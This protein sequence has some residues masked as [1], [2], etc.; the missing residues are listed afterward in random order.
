MTSRILTLPKNQQE[1][2]ED[3]RPGLILRK[4]DI[5]NDILRYGYDNSLMHPPFGVRSPNL[6]V[7]NQ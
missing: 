1:E 7:M 6:G 4:K 5:G 3:Q 2:V